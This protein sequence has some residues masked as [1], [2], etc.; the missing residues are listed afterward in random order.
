[1]DFIVPSVYENLS[2][3]RI[4]ISDYLHGDDLDQAAIKYPQYIRN[5]IGRRIM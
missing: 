1:M 3:Q 5:D 2:T 4:L